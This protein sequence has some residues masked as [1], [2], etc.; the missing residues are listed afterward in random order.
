MLARHPLS[1]FFAWARGA[2][3]LFALVAAGC[4][5]PDAVT[6]TCGSGQMACG[7]TNEC[8]NVQSDSQNCGTCGKVCG[9][10]MTCQSGACA[11][12]NGL[13]NCNGSCV[14]SDATHCG[15]C[16]NACASGPLPAGRNR[17]PSRA[18]HGSSAPASVR[19]SRR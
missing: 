8:K 3:L 2:A 11:C 5:K 13:L 18:H 15:T 17:T 4:A 1:S 9:S 16:T 10:G 12:A 6:N 19:Y 7:S 14:A